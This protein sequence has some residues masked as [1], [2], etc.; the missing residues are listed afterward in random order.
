MSGE[1]LR[2]GI[3]GATGAVGQRFVS[4][5]SRHQLFR[6]ERL[7]ASSRSAGK[8]FSTA[9]EWLMPGDPDPRLAGMIVSDCRPTDDLDLVFSSLPADEAVNIEPAFAR[10]GIPVISNTRSHRMA[11]DVP[12]II[13]E[14]NPGHLD[15]IRVQQARWKSRGY[16][17]TNPNCSTIA[18]A[19]AL[20]PIHRVFGIEKVIVSTAQAV[21][22]A[23]YPGLSV[24]SMLDNAVPYIRDEEPKL[25]SEPRKIFGTIDGDHIRSSPM[26]ISAGC[27]RVAVRDG[28]LMHISFSLSKPATETE[29]RRCWETFVPEI[30]NLSLPLCPERS[31]QYLDGDD[32]P[33]PLLDRDRGAGMTVCI[34]RLRSCPVLGWKCVAL[35]HNTIRGAAGGAIL[36]AELLAARGWITAG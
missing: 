21:S 20:A 4:M 17:V 34:G 13:P 1:L 12:L 5:L 36:V 32:R 18:M 35:G 23:G 27:T 3:L 7:M 26:V 14:V 29:I 28:H 11:S 6:I 24:M 30:S 9:V 8:P 16:I 10:A 31:V 2:A 19:L 15:L 33:Q 22:G 25:E